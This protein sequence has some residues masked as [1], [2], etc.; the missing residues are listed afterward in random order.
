MLLLVQ[1]DVLWK[2]WKHVSATLK[3][4][5]IML[6][7]SSLIALTLY[8]FRPTLQK[9]IELKL[10]WKPLFSLHN[11]ILSHTHAHLHTSFWNFF[12]FIF[13]ERTWNKFFP[14]VSTKLDEFSH[15]RNTKWWQ[16]T[17]FIFTVVSSEQGRATLTL[18]Q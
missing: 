6:K 10:N 9:K 14:P 5:I 13:Q 15:W 11:N 3:K 4:I 2:V 16:W 7:K 18:V 1:K 8:L 12:L 17:C